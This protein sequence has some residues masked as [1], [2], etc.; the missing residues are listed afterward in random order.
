MNK[1]TLE[2]YYGISGG[3]ELQ[4]FAEGEPGKEPPPGEP[5][6][7]PPAEELVEYSYNGK[8]TKLPKELVESINRR[9][10]SELH[11]WKEKHKTQQDQ[12]NA[13]SV[14]LE[15]M[16]LSTMTDKEKAE[17]AEKKRNEE[18]E[19]Y[20]SK[21]D[22]YSTKY[23]NYFMDTELFREV[24]NYDVINSKQ[25]ISLLK[26]EY[27]HEF[28]ETEDGIELAFLSG[29]SKLTVQEAVKNFLHDPQNSNLIRS[30][31]IPGAGTK[32][33]GQ[34]KRTMRTTFKRSEVADTSSEAAAEYRAAMKAGLNPTLTD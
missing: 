27:K 2:Q 16:K 13:L 6:K 11:T 28:A 17:L 22:S 30:N 18:I 8:S 26:A 20:K 12:I 14:Q 25:V 7:E 4:R 5:G 9:T 19:Q 15:E 31:L 29:G 32:A 3:I 1:Q 10:A 24:S 23:K 34:Q 21:A 33:G